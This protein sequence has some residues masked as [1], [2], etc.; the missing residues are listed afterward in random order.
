MTEY[1]ESDYCIQ[2]QQQ[3]IKITLIYQR[4]IVIYSVLGALHIAP[5]ILT[6]GSRGKYYYLCF[7]VSETLFRWAN[8][9]S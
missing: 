1:T 9:L 6:T 7:K 2:Q 3:K 8:T 4:P 5:L